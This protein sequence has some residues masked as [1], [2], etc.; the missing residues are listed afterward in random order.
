ME[1]AV[2]IRDF[3]RK[4]Q[5]STIFFGLVIGVL[6]LALWSRSVGLGFLSGTA[7]SVVNFQLMATDVFEITGKNPQKAR[8]FIIG[9]YALRFA[10]MFGFIVIITKRTDFNIFA[11]FVGLFFIQAQLIVSQA[12]SRISMNRKI[13]KG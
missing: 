10:I 8:K 3:V 1:N 9:R 6:L 5:K 13:S 7:V 2:L 12:F 4:T 11:T